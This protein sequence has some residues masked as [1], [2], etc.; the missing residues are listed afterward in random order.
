M[1]RNLHTQKPADNDFQHDPITF[2]KFGRHLGFTIM[3]FFGIR[4]PKNI[5][6][7]HFILIFGIMLNIKN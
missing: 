5:L 2:G 3:N 1:I 7:A 4:N 6:F